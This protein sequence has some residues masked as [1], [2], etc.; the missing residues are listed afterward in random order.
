MKTYTKIMW[1]VALIIVVLAS[2]VVTYKIIERDK[3]NKIEQEYD[4]RLTDI[5]MGQET[6]KKYLSILKIRDK[7][8]Y[9]ETKEMLYNS[10]SG[11]LQQ[12]L[13]GTEEYTLGE[14]GQITY[15]LEDIKAAVEQDKY[16]YKLEIKVKGEIIKE[17]YLLIGV[18]NNKIVSV[19][20]L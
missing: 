6:A 1:L 9:K 2:S 16:I 4:T 18:K 3:I 15:E 8:S 5:R 11:E 10:L 13:F 17:I 14:V 12:E 19:E 20:K 7:D